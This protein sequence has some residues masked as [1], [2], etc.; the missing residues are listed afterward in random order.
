M[1]W[2]DRRITNAILRNIAASVLVLFI[3]FLMDNHTYILS[4]LPHRFVYE[5]KEAYIQPGN[6]RHN[7]VRVAIMQKDEVVATDNVKHAL[8]ETAGDMITVGYAADRKPS[9]VRCSL[10]VT[11]GQIGVLS[12]LILGNLIF[13]WKLHRASGG[14]NHEH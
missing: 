14:N 8:G 5:Q 10:V 7:Y 12:G 3:F 6:L 1:M 9:I 2:N 13:V 11:G 4:Y